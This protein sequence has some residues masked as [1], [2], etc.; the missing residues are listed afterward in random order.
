[1][2]VHVQVTVVCENALHMNITGEKCVPGPDLLQHSPHTAT[3]HI[4]PQET[5][6]VARPLLTSTDLQ[7]AAA[8]IGDMAVVKMNPAP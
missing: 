1:M 7:A 2:H 6:N 4:E 3:D 8:C 5:V